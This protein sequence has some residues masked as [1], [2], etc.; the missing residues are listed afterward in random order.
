MINP[1]NL[2]VE[3]FVSV[4]K[5]DSI[6]AKYIPEEEHKEVIHTIMQMLDNVKCQTCNELKGVIC[7]K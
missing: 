2:G 7:G 4:L 1:Q 6:L 3:N 5:I